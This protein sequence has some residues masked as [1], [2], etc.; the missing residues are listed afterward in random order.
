VPE[1]F[2]ETMIE[3]ADCPVFMIGCPRSGTNLLYDT[4][5]IGPRIRLYRGRIPDYDYDHGYDYQVFIPRLGKLDRIENRK[6]ISGSTSPTATSW[7]VLSRRSPDT[8][9]SAAFPHPN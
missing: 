4:L 1:R 7:G 3:R 2:G 5:A 8:C 9:M 6:K